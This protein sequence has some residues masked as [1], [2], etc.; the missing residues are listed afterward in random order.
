MKSLKAL[1]FVALAKGPQDPALTRRAALVQRLEHQRALALDAGYMRT[2]QRWMPNE[3]GSKSLVEQRKRVRPWWTMDI[4][5]AMSLVVRY[6]SR[7]IEFEKGKNAIVIPSRDQLV[8][9]IDTLIA[10]VKA[11]ELDDQLAYNAKVRTATKGK[12]VA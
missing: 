8:T 4:T 11:G 10:A 3:Q 9:V 1:T 7:P 2:V 12:K 5:G 6:G